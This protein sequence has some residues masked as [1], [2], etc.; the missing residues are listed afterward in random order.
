[1]LRHEIHP[2]TDFAIE[3]IQQPVFDDIRFQMEDHISVSSYP[4]TYKSVYTH[5]HTHI[6]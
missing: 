4:Y 5:V 1:M 3:M 2:S 6:F